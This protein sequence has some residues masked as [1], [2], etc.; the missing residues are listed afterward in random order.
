MSRHLDYDRDVHEVSRL[1]MTA[2][3][4]I[5]SLPGCIQDVDLRDPAL[6]GDRNAGS[7]GGDAACGANERLDPNAPSTS[8]CAPCT[9]VD[10]TTVCP[11]DYDASP[12]PFPVCEGPEGDF[13]CDTICTG[14]KSRCNAY[15]EIQGVG[16]VRDCALLRECCDLLAASGATPCCQPDEVLFCFEGSGTDQW[17]YSF[18]CLSTACCGT[19]CSSDLGCDTTFQTCQDNRCVPGCDVASEYCHSDASGCICRPL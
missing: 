1:L 9:Y 18:L 11:C 2:E 14:D 19:V 6:L 17:H 3:L 13:T 10:P 15:R 8:A 16:R 4:L 7:S 12:A 5:V